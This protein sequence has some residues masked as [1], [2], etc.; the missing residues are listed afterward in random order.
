[1][2]GI[3]TGRRNNVEFA[4]ERWAYIFFHD[5]FSDP[6]SF[7][8]FELYL[9]ILSP[10]GLWKVITAA[11]LLKLRVMRSI[12]PPPFCFRWKWIINCSDAVDD[13]N[14]VTT[15]LRGKNS[16]STLP[17][18]SF[19]LRIETEATV[20]SSKQDAIVFKSVRERVALLGKWN[21]KRKCRNAFRESPVNF[22]KPG[23]SEAKFANI[24][25]SNEE[26]LSN[27]PLCKS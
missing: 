22:R 26:K 16:G 19:T 1:M 3:T 5:N 24:R 12:S 4:Y 20:L 10:S 21:L 8:N 25:L 17:L 7:K 18:N 15:T 27:Y 9:N 14:S 2:H 6:T 13:L 11:C 23:T